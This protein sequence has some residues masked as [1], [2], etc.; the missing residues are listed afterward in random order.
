[1]VDKEVERMRDKHRKVECNY[2]V[3]QKRIHL[4]L[5]KKRNAEREIDTRGKRKAENENEKELLK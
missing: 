3:K 4:L 1:M 2:S 5:R